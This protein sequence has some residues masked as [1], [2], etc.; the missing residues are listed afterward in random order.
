MSRSQTTLLACTSNIRHR[1]SMVLGLRGDQADPLAEGSVRCSRV[2]PFVTHYP[3]SVQN[4]REFAE[5]LLECGGF[6]IC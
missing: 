5:F 3:L 6:E 2:R 4:V 1:L